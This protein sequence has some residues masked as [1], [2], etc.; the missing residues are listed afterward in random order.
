MPTPANLVHETSD[1]EGISFFTLTPANGRQTFAQA[2]GTGGTDVF[3]YFISDQDS[4]D[5][6]RGTGHM[7]SSTVMV[8]DTVLESSNLDSPVD[9]GPGTK[10]IM[11]DMP[12]SAYLAKLGDSGLLWAANGS[13]SAPSHSFTDDSDTG[14]YRESANVY[15]IGTGGTKRVSVSS[16]GLAVAIAAAAALAVGAN[17]ATNPVFQVDAATASVATGVKITGAAAAGG[18]A[19]AAISSGTDESLTLDAKGAGTVTVGGTSTGAITLARNVSVTGTETITSSNASALTVGRQGATNPVLQID[20]SAATVVTGWKLTG[21]AAAGGA[22]LAVISSGT[23]ENATIDAKGAGT[24]GIGTVS[25]GA[26]TLGRATTV[27]TSLTTPVLIGGTGTTSTITIKPTSGVGTT[28]ADII[29]ANGNNGATERM[30]LAHAGHFLIGHTTSVVMN[31]AAV[32]S[33]PRMQLHGTDTDTGK[34]CFAQYR[35][36]DGANGAQHYL[37]HSRGTTPGVHTTLQDLDPVGS[38]ITGASDGTQFL[39]ATSVQS[40]VDGTPSTGVMRGGMNLR[41]NRGTD[42]TSISLTIKSTGSVLIGYAQDSTAQVLGSD[43]PI[44]SGST[45][46]PRLAVHGLST[47]AQVAAYRWANS[48]GGAALSMA[49]SRGATVG[50]RVIVQSGD[51]VGTLTFFADDGTNWPAAASISGAVDGTPGAGDMPGRLVFSTTADGADSATERM[52]I[53]SSGR[54]LVGHTASINAT[55][56]PVASAL[57]VHGTTPSAGSTTRALWSA[58]TSAPN[59]FFLKSRGAAIGTRGIVASGDSLG[60]LNFRGDDGTNFIAA[61]SITAVADGTPG[62]NDMPG[63]LIFGTTAVGASAITE[64]MRIDSSGRV[65]VGGTA[66]IQIASID[67]GLQLHGAAVGSSSQLNARY[68]ADAGGTFFFMAKSRHATV[69]SH[70]I[71]Q[72][73]DT[74]GTIAAYGSNGTTFDSAA[75][76]T[77]E[78]D[79]TPGASTDMP[80]RI[81]LW[82]TPD[83]SATA[84]ERMRISSTG[85]VLIAHTAD[86][87]IGSGSTQSP[88]LAVHGLSTDAQAAAYRWANSTGGAALSMAKSRGATVGSRAIVQSGDT[89]GTISFFGD[90]GTNW[91]AAANIVAAV[92]GTPGAGDMPGRLVFSTTADGAASA[93]ER[94]RIDSSGNVNI[95]TAGGGPR[96]LVQT[97][98]AEALRMS[99]SAANGG[100]MVWAPDA[101]TLTYQG[102]MK[103]ILGT[104]NAS[105]FAIIGTGANVF[106]LGT[107]SVERMRIDSSG[108]VGIGAASNGAQL[109]VT[110]VSPDPANGVDTF[111]VVTTGAYGG[112]FGLIDSTGNIGIWAQDTGGS[113]VIG[114]G[115]SLGTVTGQ[116]FIN[117]TGNIKTGASS[118][119]G[120]TEGT[121]QFVLFNGTAPA[122]TL[123]NGVS[124]YSSSGDA[125]AMNAAG[126]A[127]LLTLGG[128]LPAILSFKVSVNFNAG[129]TDTAI[130]ITLPAGYTRYAIDFVRLSGASGTLTT[131]TVGVFSSTGGGGTTI[132]TSGAITVSTASEDTANNSQFFLIAAGATPITF[133]GAN[134]YVRVGTP[135]GSAATGTMTIGIIPAS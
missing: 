93:T 26:I 21:A 117:T 19:I 70:T 132:V 44:G 90:D 50:S 109:L 7:D 120:T 92:D 135:Q 98:A 130:P 89:L 61:A 12:A 86:V 29:F 95:G 59:A 134:V 54:V 133:T 23:D 64:R 56:T 81:R 106:A 39:D 80:G 78:V 71:V 15:A 124:H 118:S 97:T 40:F 110:S 107:N 4:G 45:Q 114:Y 63:R 49:K 65:I 30:R 18:V 66:S 87:P 131:A 82:T 41:T 94:M 128:G 119:R 32:G 27:A 115:S 16:S 103:A 14:A 60:T 55:V 13:A 20:A 85:Q 11:N 116:Y 8:R 123:S 1:S 122:G 99:S 129:S 68:S 25:T 126:K 22:A 2:F 24:I 52:R 48:T 104:G 77:F 37:N 31:K 42:E 17:G 36:Y 101:S 53:D 102:S 43:V 111:G 35:W 83:S 100:Y 57:Q 91:P 108:K 9:F 88:R 5:W 73:D 3:D 105:D 28:N 38:L 121:N 58:D 74:L 46:S 84:L 69:G 113:L 96:L 76:I 67:N 34:S 72:S 112:G 75:R 62:T 125:Y 10:D 33:E 47:D 6:E 79:G 127:Q 51:T